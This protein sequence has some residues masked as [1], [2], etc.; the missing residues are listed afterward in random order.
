LNVLDVAVV[1]SV[2]PLSIRAAFDTASGPVALIG[3]NG[4]GK[5]SL[6]RLIL[7][8]LRPTSGRIVLDGEA[9]FDSE[10]NIDVPTEDRRFGYLPQG[11]GLFPHLNV[12]ENVEFGLLDD[13]LLGS[14]KARRRRAREL[15]AELDVEQLAERKPVL[16]S[17]GERQRVALA[18]ALARRPRALLLDEPLAA[19]DPGARHRVR[20]FLG[21]YLAELGLPTI[22]VT[23]DRRDAEA[24]ARTLVVVEAGRIVQLGT[25]DELRAQPASAFLAEFQGTTG[26][27]ERPSR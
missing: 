14:S 11:Y 27:P 7:G 1:A 17:G 8:V 4:S 15:L 2:G 3:P 6:L 25:L 20:K 19:L 13:P 22:I 9:V 5:T 16:L 21:E 18:R 10:A 12:V 26:T 24:V 23:H